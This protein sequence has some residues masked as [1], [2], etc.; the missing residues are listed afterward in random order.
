MSAIASI[1]HREFDLQSYSRAIAKYPMLDKDTEFDLGRS[2]QNG[3]VSQEARDKLI[4]PHLRLVVATAMKYRKYG[5]DMKDLIQEGNIGLMQAVKKFEPE[6]GNRLNTYAVWWIK[7]AI[8]EFI[9]NNRSLIKMSNTSRNKKVVRVLMELQKKA[10]NEGNNQFSNSIV[11]KAAELTGVDEVIVKII[12]EQIAPTAS[13]DAA[14][15]SKDS[16]DGGGDTLGSFIAD[17]A[18]SPEDIAI[19]QDESEKRNGMLKNALMQLPQ[20]DR[21]IFVA[22]RL[23]DDPETLEV[24]ALRY[25]LSRERIRQIENDAFAKIQAVVRREASTRNWR[26]QNTRFSEN[27]RMAVAA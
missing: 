19:Q 20:R 10:A 23:I 16:E 3:G 26:A 14:V 11:A 15:K 13:L 2:L 7:A 12:A 21:E 27:H 4:N 1:S 5:F 9:F 18:A 6:K 8:Q 24:L 22:R 17:T 25:S